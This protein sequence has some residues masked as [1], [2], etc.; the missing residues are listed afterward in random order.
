MGPKI[1]HWI[2][3]YQASYTELRFLEF[4]PQATESQQKASPK[5][6]GD[7]IWGLFCDKLMAERKD[8][9]PLEET[10]RGMCDSP[11]CDDRS[12]LTKRGWIQN[13]LWR[14]LEEQ[15]WA[16]AQNVCLW[17]PCPLSLLDDLTAILQFQGNL[18]GVPSSS[19]GKRHSVHKSLVRY[20]K[21]A[22]SSSLFHC[23]LCEHR[24]QLCLLSSIASDSIQIE[25]WR[26]HK[27]HAVFLNEWLKMSDKPNPTP[28]LPQTVKKKKKSHRW[29]VKCIYFFNFERREV[30]NLL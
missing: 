26:E 21:E 13:T 6:K 7:T 27:L 18:L 11:D 22:H 28:P 24:W 15:S 20:M 3:L 14:N 2:R 23:E 25:H 1:S 17:P 5:E 4:T 16:P 8:M 30:V 29:I 12:Q 10:V 19:P 9:A